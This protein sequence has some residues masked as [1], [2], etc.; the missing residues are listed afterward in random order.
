MIGWVRP[1]F[2]F[3]S[4]MI[5]LVAA[6]PAR[7]LA[8]ISGFLAKNRKNAAVETIHS[9][10]MPE[11]IRRIRKRVMAIALGLLGSVRRHRRDQ[12]VE[13]SGPAASPYS[14]APLTPGREDAL[15]PRVER[16]PHSVAEQVERKC[17][18]QQRSCREHQVPPGDL[19]VRLCPGQ[20][21]APASSWRLDTQPE[22]GQG[23]L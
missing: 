6:R 19:V 13:L 5:A 15:G 14:S 3:T 18:D 9:T 8:T 12:C 23:R 11:R 2:R 10:T 4:L 17:R 1:R 21:V 7:D 20:D 16:V 22:E